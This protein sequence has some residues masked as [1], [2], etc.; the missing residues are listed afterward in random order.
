MIDSLWDKNV[1]LLPLS[2]D[3]QDV[4]K[5]H[6]QFVAYGNAALSS[7]VGTPFGAGKACY[8]DG[9]GDYLRCP[10]TSSDFNLGTGDFD[11]SAWGYIVG[12]SAV[13]GS[14]ER[15]A[16]IL[17]ADNESN[18]A[19]FEFAI[20]G[21][22]STTGTHLYLWNGTTGCSGGGTISKNVWHFV[23]AKRVSGIVTFYLDEVQLGSSVSYNVQFGSSSQY[24]HVG[25]RPITNYNSIMNGYISNVRVTKG[26]SRPTS[27]PTAPFPRP[28]I[29]GTVR[30]ASGALA[31]KTILFRD[32][33]TQQWLGGANS[34]PT[35][36]VYT[37]HPPDFGEVIS[38][39][40][41]GLF[42]P[43]TDECVFDLDPSRGVVG[44]QLAFDNKGHALSYYN[45]V[46]INAD[47]VSFEF[48]G[49]A[50]SIPTTSADYILGTDD[51]SI[52]M[53]FYPITGGRTSGASNRILQIGSNSTAG[54]L[55]IDAYST[56]NP[57]TL[58]VLFYDTAYRTIC[59]GGGTTLANNTWHKL[60]LRRVNGVFTTTVNDTTLAT[61]GAT[62]YNISASQLVLGGNTSNT[63]SFNG[64]IGKVRISRGARR[65]AAAIPASR[66]LTLPAD[67][68][69]AN[70]DLIYGR[71]TPGAP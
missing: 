8:F 21:N 2:E 59:A 64:R 20:G 17:S 26:S 1:L 71:V 3:L 48:D 22:A 19:S 67:G 47:G 43:P 70:N 40:I 24:M 50:D 62:A 37:F 56:N 14:S 44:G 23:R 5:S 61:T 28:T 36:G 33:S 69:S 57:M 68:V 60:Q 58:E 46:K 9:T 7:A 65:A 16:M 10:V 6:R 42:D 12:D 30:D 66:L 51:F 29:S 18:S 31:A 45:E 35:T 63:E 4:S 27:L 38:E 54:T 34:D 39:A 52:E 55:V 53:E 11:I 13:N 41:D 25:G 15:H 49:S 32:R